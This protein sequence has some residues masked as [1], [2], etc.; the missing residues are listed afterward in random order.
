MT[1]GIPVPLAGGK[2]VALV[3][4]ADAELVSR[5]SWY[6][7][8]N[9]HGGFYARAYNPDSGKL[10]YMHQLL[11]GPG[12]DHANRN[13]LDN[14]RE[15]LRPATRSQNGA[16]AGPRGGTS[17]FKGVSWDR[18]SGRWVAFIYIDG[19]SRWLGSF[20]AEEPAARAYDQAAKEAWGEFSWLNFPG[21]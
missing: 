3:D 16:N 15:N 4:A 9:R 21:R 6:R 11:A 20:T 5:F 1:E 14:R 18:R 13:G 12:T 19:H 2:G 10:I 7:H 8:T 17:R